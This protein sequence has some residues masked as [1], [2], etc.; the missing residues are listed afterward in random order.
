MDIYLLAVVVVIALCGYKYLFR[1]PKSIAHMPEVS[2]CAFLLSFLRGES[3]DDRFDRLFRPKLE[4]HGYAR[5]WTQGRWEIVISDAAISK[6]VLFRNNDFLKRNPDDD[7]SMLL[8]VRRMFGLINITVSDGDEWRRRRK[9]SNSAFKRTLSPE[10]LAKPLL[11]MMCA[12]DDSKG[13][14]MLVLDLLRRATLDAYGHVMLDHDFKALQLGEEHYS[15]TGYAELLFAVGDPLFFALPELENIIPHRRAFHRKGQEYREFLRRV[16]RQRAKR[17]DLGGDDLL[18]LLVNDMLSC[19]EDRLSEEDVIDDMVAIL[20]A[21]HDTIA[22]AMTSILYF[23]AKHPDVQATLRQ[24]VLSVMGRSMAIPTNEQQR[25]MPYLEQVIKEGLR[26]VTTVPQ[27]RR[28]CHTEQ[29]LSCGLVIPAR[30]SIQIESWGIHHNANIFPNPHLFDPNRFLDPH[31][32]ESTHWLP[33]G[34]GTRMCA[35]KNFAMLEQRTM[36][37]LILQRYHLQLDAQSA[38]EPRPRF[39]PASL[40]HPLDVN[41][42]FSPLNAEK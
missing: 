14:S 8:L 38:Q 11:D 2:L 9:V 35:G 41:I 34:Y 15:V 28:Y 36:L 26:I 40:V 1:V 29:T 32:P 25:D 6:E 16:I 17:P 18:S 4:K 12:I 19:R 13:K 3:V 37:I 27:L 42:H 21:G 20:V 31:G 5:T 10:M 39:N 7:Q 24:E 23:L 22:N 30:T 33:F